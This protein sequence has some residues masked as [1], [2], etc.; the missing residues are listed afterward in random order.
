MGAKNYMCLVQVNRDLK[1]KDLIIRLIYALLLAAAWFVLLMDTDYMDY[2]P[3]NKCMKND[4]NY[5]GIFYL[6]KK[7]DFRTVGF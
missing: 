2:G 5:E 4:V 1:S 3:M 6:G 7:I